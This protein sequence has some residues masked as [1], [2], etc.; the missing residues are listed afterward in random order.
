MNK[1]PENINKIDKIEK[2]IDQNRN[3]IIEQKEM[4]DFLI[5]EE[6][7]QELTS[8]LMQLL[9]NPKSFPESLKR[10]LLEN[11]L[12]NPTFQQEIKTKIYNNQQLSLVQIQLFY[13]QAYLDLECFPKPILD[14]SPLQRFQGYDPIQRY[15]GGIF[16]NYLT[17][18]YKN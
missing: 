3:T 17:Q 10:G 15:G 13:L 8:A 9:T 6:N 1:I 11:T 18:K 14:M 5:K 16:L 2:K 4:L 7:V 12:Y